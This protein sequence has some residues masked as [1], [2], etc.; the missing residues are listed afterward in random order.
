MLADFKKDAANNPALRY[1][2]YGIYLVIIVAIII[3]MVKVFK[4][5]QS[6]SNVAGDILTNA[7]MAAKTG[8]PVDRVTY[9][10]TTAQNLW[11]KS[12]HSTIWSIVGAKDYTPENFVVAINNM[13]SDVEVR[14]LNQM[15]VQAGG[16]P[17]NTVIS[18]Y[19]GFWDSY[20]ARINVA[21][22]ATIKTI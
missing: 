19:N 15:Y 3:V 13:Q 14:M 5:L 7:E 2:M 1:T 6:A 22:Y 11:D 10:R 4:G 21:N 16:D 8:V 9:I 17:L 12:S 20:I 18:W